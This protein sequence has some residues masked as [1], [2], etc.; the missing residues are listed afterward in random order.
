MIRTNLSTRP[1]YNERAV[2]LWLLLGAIAVLAAT[3]F[4][5]S[6]MLRYSNSNTELATQRRERRGAGGRTPHARAA[7]AGERRLAAD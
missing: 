2:R 5:V 6:R 1:F 3:A 7:A 4:N